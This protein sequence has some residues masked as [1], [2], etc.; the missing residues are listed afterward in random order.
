MALS[1]TIALR[2][3][4]QRLLK[5]LTTN[6]YYEQ[7]PDSAA[8]PYLVY[9]LSEL[10][11]NYGKTLMELEINIV[12]YGTST[13]RAETI[14]DDVQD[15]LNK[16]FYIGAEVEFIVYKNIRQRVVEDDKQVVRRRLTFE[17]Q[18]HELK[19]E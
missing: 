5:T 4:L 1:K 15:A 17:I 3:E 6:V 18:L 13:T 8:H 12:D 19:G 14:A 2:T 16:Y 7:A 10:S 9:E 11:Y